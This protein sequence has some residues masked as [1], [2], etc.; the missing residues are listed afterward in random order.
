MYG[1]PPKPTPIE[2]KN[3]PPLVN[4]PSPIPFPNADPL[5]NIPKLPLRCNS[6]NP[7]TKAAHN[8]E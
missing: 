2:K 7:L 5:A 1:P 4:G 6:H 3:Q 8:Y